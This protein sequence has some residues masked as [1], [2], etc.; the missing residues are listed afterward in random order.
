MAKK[1]LKDL[2]EALDTRRKLLMDLDPTER[3][4]LR[5]DKLVFLE[6][7]AA[8]PGKYR[9]ETQ[10]RVKNKVAQV[11]ARAARTLERM[12]QGND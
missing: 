9:P 6:D 5:V 10:V 1:P 4:Q 7:E 2:R 12:E 3:A 11:D 8:K